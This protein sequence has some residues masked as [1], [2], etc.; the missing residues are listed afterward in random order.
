MGRRRGQRKGWLREQSGQWRLTYRLYDVLG[1][2]KREDVYIGPA[3]GPG[4]LTAKQAERRA[5]DDYLSKA[6]DIS[7][8]PKATIT[9]TEFWD[10]KYWPQAELRLRKSTRGQYSS[11][12]GHWLKPRIGSTSVALVTVEHIEQTLAEIASAGK[13][14][15]TVKHARKVLSALFTRAK[16]LGYFTGD[17]PA[18]LVELQPATSVRKPYAL[19]VAQARAILAGKPK[20]AQNG[21]LATPN[22][23]LHMIRAAL[24]TGMNAAELCGLR[25]SQVNLTDAPA[26]DIP[27]K[28]IGVREHWYRGEAGALKTGNR[29][30]NIPICGALA[31]L[32]EEIRA[33]G[34]FLTGADRVFCS[35]NGKPLTENNIR[36]RHLA[37]LAES[38]GLPY[39]GW[40]IFRHTVA[41]WCAEL[42]MHEVDRQVLLGHAPATMTQRYTHAELERIRGVLD[43]LAARIEPAK[44]GSNVVEIRRIG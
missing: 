14:P 19:S 13:S 39:L 2:P 40:H 5:W 18:G 15:A 42:G 31:K 30:R 38:L 3:E 26:G 24:L 25:W 21:S 34:V 4:K 6:D 32:L 27:A 20:G 43:Q 10:S 35:R 37:P 44:T 11:L 16:R 7:R 36:R 22:R 28:C 41:S 17:N 9:V 1:R 12:W 33:R 8:K 23:F 29:Y